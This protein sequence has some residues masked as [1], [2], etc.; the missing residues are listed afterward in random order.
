MSDLTPGVLHRKVLAAGL[1][2]AQAGWKTRQFDNSD[3]V[4]AFDPSQG[5]ATEERRWYHATV[6]K[7][8]DNY[9]TVRFDEARSDAPPAWRS[10]RERTLFCANVRTDLGVLEAMPIPE[11]KR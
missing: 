6:L 11:G 8:F 7:R 10:G 4:W 3:R 2:W 9:I 1:D 5:V